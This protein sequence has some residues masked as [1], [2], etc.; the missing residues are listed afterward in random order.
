MQTS[1]CCCHEGQ[2]RIA[3]LLLCNQRVLMLYE[4][5]Y[6]PIVQYTHYFTPA[7]EDAYPSLYLDSCMF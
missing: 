5:P 3:P 4:P 7:F 2:N 6:W 1:V